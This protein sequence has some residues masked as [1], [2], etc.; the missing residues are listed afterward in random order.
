MPNLLINLIDG[1]GTLN[2]N[3]FVLT[4]G[5]FCFAFAG[6]FTVQYP[7]MFRTRA[8]EQKVETKSNRS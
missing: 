5:C 2:Q 4:L 8:K 3:R 7:V 1:H 6:F